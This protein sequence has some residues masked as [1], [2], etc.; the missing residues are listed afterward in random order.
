VREPTVELAGRLGLDAVRFQGNWIPHQLRPATGDG[1]FFVGDSA[2]HCLPLTA[3][4][5]RPAFYFALAL[6]RELRE[7]LAGRAA[8]DDA[9]RRY[10]AF[11]HAH[12]RP[13]AAML[14]TQ[15]LVGRLTGSGA[16]R[17]A[18]RLTGRRRVAPWIFGHY[19]RITPPPPAPAAAV[20]PARRPQ[21]APAPA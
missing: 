17:A 1:V 9:L 11:S 2:G 5:I 21:P 14:M 12:R 8:R 18:V 20:P 19:F 10:A 15:H 13:F 16:L 6:G 7:V 4:G 3:E